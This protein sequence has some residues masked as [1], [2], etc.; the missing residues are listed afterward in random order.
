MKKITLLIF[1][2]G[3]LFVFT[4]CGNDIEFNSPAIQGY[5]N[6]DIWRA[7]SYAADIDFG[8]FVIEGRLTSE[9]VQLITTNDARGTYDL[10]IDSGNVAIYVDSNGAVYSTKNVPDTNINLSRP[11]GQIIVDDI[12]NADPSGIY[13]TFWFNAYTADGLHVVNFNRGVFY[14]VRLVGGLEQI[15]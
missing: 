7:T 12:D 8:G 13:G 2:F 15:P 9:K 3:S 6:G 11:E 14:N 4:N 10:G 5:K 1:V